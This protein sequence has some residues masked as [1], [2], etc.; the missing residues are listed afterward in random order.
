MAKPSILLFGAHGWIGG[1]VRAALEQRGIRHTVAKSRADDVQAVLQ[2]LEAVQPTHVM[3]FIGRTH[4][5]LSD[6]RVINTIDYLEENGKLVENI[7]DN[8]YSPM[9]LAHLCNERG[10]HYTYLG[11]GCIFGYDIEHPLECAYSGKGFAEE[12]KPNFFGSSYS[13]VKG[14]TDM[15]MRNYK[16]NVLNLR[17]RMPIV[18]SHN[19]RN[20]ITKICTY[21]RICSIPNSMSVLDE[22]IPVMIDMVLHRECGTY[23]LT[24][25]GVISHNEI[26]E[27]YR[28]SVDPDFTWKNFSADEQAKVIASGRSSNRLE[29]DK[30]T[31]KY[32]V[33]DIKTA[34][35][36]AVRRMSK[37]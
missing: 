37:L 4:G 8:L 13:I 19:A 25:P 30:L 36:T 33:C 18:G 20:F 10:I 32:P 23:N 14:F 11:T 17:I 5:T 16:N 6:G 26:L 3:S 24:N 29:T 31:Q 28:E 7:R 27:M 15:L 22:L 21:E 2:E 34:V 1:Q 9:V 35:R 12:S